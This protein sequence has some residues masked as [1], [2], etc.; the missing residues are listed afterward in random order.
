MA[1]QSIEIW[2]CDARLGEPQLSPF[3]LHLSISDTPTVG[4]ALIKSGIA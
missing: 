1:K 4:L 2:I 3:T